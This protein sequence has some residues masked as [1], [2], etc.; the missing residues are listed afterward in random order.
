[1]ALC[2]R[3][4]R[5]GPAC[6]SRNAGNWSATSSRWVHPRHLQNN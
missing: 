6:R 1:M 2:A 4:C 5:Y 3:V